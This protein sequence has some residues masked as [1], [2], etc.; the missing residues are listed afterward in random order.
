M[1]MINPDRRPPDDDDFRP[2][3][4]QVGLP[5]YALPLLICSAGFDL[6]LSWN[7]KSLSVFVSVGALIYLLGHFVWK[8]R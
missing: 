6:Y 3:P 1:L 4:K 7:S 5:F 2:P 8:K